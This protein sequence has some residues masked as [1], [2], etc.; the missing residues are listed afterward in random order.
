[1]Y[2]YILSRGTKE[3][4]DFTVRVL[5]A[6]TAGIMVGTQVSG[7]YYNILRRYLYYTY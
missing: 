5:N 2:T 1:M 4:T 7:I 3:Q 6:Q